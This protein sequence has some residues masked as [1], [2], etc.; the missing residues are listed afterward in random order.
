MK[1]TA[2][3]L[4]WATEFADRLCAPGIICRHEQCGGHLEFVGRET[5]GEVVRVVWTCVVCGHRVSEVV[6]A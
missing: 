2:T 3:E 1:M 4:K 6:D 5:I